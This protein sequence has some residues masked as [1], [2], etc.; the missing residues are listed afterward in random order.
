MEE[1]IRQILADVLG[2]DAT[3]ID[4]STSTDNT[5]SWDSLAHINIVSALEQEYGITLDI[6]EIES[7]QSLY[8]IIEILDRKL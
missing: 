7:M 5:E 6:D 4:G 3:T 8:D 2:L 1:Q